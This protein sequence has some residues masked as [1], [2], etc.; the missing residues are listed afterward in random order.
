MATHV[1]GSPNL[2]GSAKIYTFPARGRFAHGGADHAV[3]ATDL[4]SVRN[5]VSGSGWYHEE[6]IQDALKAEQTRK[7]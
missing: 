2:P 4:S 5:F 3:P 7:S 6:A 1:F